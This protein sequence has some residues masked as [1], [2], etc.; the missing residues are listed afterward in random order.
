[1][2]SV[3]RSTDTLSCKEK[4]TNFLTADKV[5]SVRS[6]SIFDYPTQNDRLKQCDE[7]LTL[8]CS[9]NNVRGPIV[10]SSSMTLFS[11][12]GDNAET[13]SARDTEVDLYAPNL[14]PTSIYMETLEDD[15]QFSLV[16]ESLS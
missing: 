7:F 9:S 2:P 4:F 12:A 15:L 13:M 10:Q 3:D 5:S 8:M 16:L 1:M 6:D 11:L 14:R